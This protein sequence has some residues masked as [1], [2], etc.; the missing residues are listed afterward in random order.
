MIDINERLENE[1]I[2]QR[3]LLSEEE[4]FDI[5]EPS[6]HDIQNFIKSNMRN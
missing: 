5:I 4:C 1:V 3:Q 2:L 6:I